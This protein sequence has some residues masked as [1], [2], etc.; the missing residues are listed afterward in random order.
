[1]SD[2]LMELLEKGMTALSFAGRQKFSV[3]RAIEFSQNLFKNGF[4]FKKLTAAVVACLEIFTA[5]I[6]DGGLTP[7]GEELNLDGYK[8]VFSDEFNG[9]SLNTDIWQYRGSGKRRGG[10]NGESQ[11]EVKDGNLLMTAEYLENGAYGSGW[12][13]GMISLKQKYCKGYFEI[14][15]KINKGRDFWSA[16]WIQAD[17]PYDHEIS[18]GGIGGAEIDIFENLSSEDSNLLKR[19]SVS[20]TVHCN[21]GDDDPENLDSYSLGKF[22]GKNIYDE[23]N[24]YG[25]KWTDDEYIFYINGVETSR[26]SWCKGVSE[27]P[28]EV[29]VSLEIPENISYD[30]NSGYTSQFTVDYVKIWQLE[31]TPAPEVNPQ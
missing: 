14:R 17:H 3:Y 6:F 18:R 15:C 11:V 26:T 28:E 10:F 4:S 7:L 12:Y 9:D 19:G 23:Y 5:V 21:G 16:F 27:V 29:I 25:C 24:T 31:D 30:K 13:V 22:K 8:L 2:K 20:Q 1:M